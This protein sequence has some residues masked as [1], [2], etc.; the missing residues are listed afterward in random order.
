M[1]TVAIT[2]EPLH[3]QPGAHVELLREAGF[4]VSF[5][6]QPV[7]FMEDETVDA[8]RGA[9]AV[10]AG[11]E[12][13]TDSVFARLPDLRVISR[14]GVGYDMIDV[15]AASR[16]GVVVAITPDGNFDA[17]A[18]HTFALLLAVARRI[19]ASDR[20]VRQGLWLKPGL[21]PLRGQTLGIVGLG[22]IGRAVANRAVAFQMNVVA[23]DP[24][25]PP[26][27][28]QQRGIELTDMRDLLARSDFVTLHLPMSSQ[29]QGLV[30]RDLI[31]KMKRGA[32]LINTARGGLIVERDLVEALR[33]GQLAGAGLDV[34]AAEPPPRDHPL[35]SLDNVVLTAHTAACDTKALTDMP[36]H[37]ARNIIAL[38]A[39]RWP[40]AAIVNPELGPNWS[41]SR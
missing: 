34:L 40:A 28:A 18:E 30:N 20:E 27:V 15:D 19:V 13:Y 2:P 38:A 10:V 9:S 6:T 25:P 37:A 26:A 29:T 12:P 36:L 7:L 32:C 4:D 24:Y 1:S 21:M 31:S 11:S 5:P 14:C 35:L 41:W 22:R 33:S 8:L 17:V 3:K 39:G 16:H 23:Y